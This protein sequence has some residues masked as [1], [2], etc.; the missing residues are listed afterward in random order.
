MKKSLRSVPVKMSRLADLT[1]DCMRNG[2]NARA[3]KMLQ[4][5]EWLLQNGTSQVAGAVSAVYVY[6]L[7]M[8]LDLHP[9]LRKRYLAKLPPGLMNEY[10]R[11]LYAC[12]M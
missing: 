11:Q 10:R 5:A 8:F 7:S 6:T 9:E 4:A 3:E 12:G 2:R 1:I